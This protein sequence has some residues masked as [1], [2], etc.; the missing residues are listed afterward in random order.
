MCNFLDINSDNYF[1][2]ADLTTLGYMHKSKTI[3]MVNTVPA[4]H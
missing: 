4:K 3:N 2:I 1:F